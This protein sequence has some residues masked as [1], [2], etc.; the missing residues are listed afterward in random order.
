MKTIV[1]LTGVIVVSLILGFFIGNKEGLETVGQQTG[2]AVASEQPTAEAE[3][4]SP[5][6]QQDPQ[7]IFYNIF[8]KSNIIVLF[9]VLA[10]YYIL[11]IILNVSQQTQY[12][13]MGRFFDIVVFGIIILYIA[14]TYMFLPLDNQEAILKETGNSYM[15]YLDDPYSLF[16]LS[17]FLIVFYC[18]LFF[19]NITVNGTDKSFIVSIVESLAWITFAILIIVDFFK[20][21]LGISILSFITDGISSFW[22]QLPKE[23]AVANAVAV[24]GGEKD[25]VFHISNNIYDAN[26][27]EAVCSSFG[28]TLANYNQL[29]DYYKQGG[30][31][32]GYGW[33]A[34]KLALFPTQ[35]SSWQKLQNTDHK[36]VCGRPGING[37]AF[38]PSIKFGV[39][40]FG[41]KP[42]ATPEDLLA[43]TTTV[44]PKTPEE[45]AMEQKIQ[46]YKDNADKMMDVVSFNKTQW[47]EWG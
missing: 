22:N 31:F 19:F 25:E 21:V 40:C 14:I 47:S 3:T 28:A 5:P 11:Y 27:A 26:D 36:N 43:M 33:S 45:I 17:L 4:R 32:C 38:D 46:F 23:Q 42:K 2:S 16:S 10:I 20:Y 37:G 1:L 29:E 44:P 7:T 30:E 8:N 15:Q 9:W 24:Q 39:N 34:D 12:V 41:K 6:Q 35:E 18:I 13:S